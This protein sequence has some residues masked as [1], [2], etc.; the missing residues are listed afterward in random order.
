MSRRWTA[1]EDAALAKRIAE[2]LSHQCI[3]DELGRTLESIG[4]RAQ[5]LRISNPEA[6]KR[7]ALA[8]Q[9][10]A[11]ADRVAMAPVIEAIKAGWTQ[12][13]RAL[14][15]QTARETTAKRQYRP[16]TPEVRQRMTAGI[17]A[18]HR[19]RFAWIPADL[20]PE[21]NRLV[22]AYSAAA[23]RE[24]IK[25]VVAE[26]EAAMSPFERQM[27]KV[28]AGAGIVEVRP[29]PRSEPGYSI[30]GSSMAMFG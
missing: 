29:M 7:N 1:A 24:E 2:G 25:R 4:W 3:G 12:E 21:Y 28:R 10:A 9:R 6:S 26:R 20:R 19:R 8:A 30:I 11:W 17:K 13:R 16:P 15:A 18:W 5:R 22:R 14:Q 27:A 23:A